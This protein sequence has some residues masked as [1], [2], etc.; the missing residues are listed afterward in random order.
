MTQAPP[1]Q[2]FIP[3]VLVVLIK[4]SLKMDR[5]DIEFYERLEAKIGRR[6]NNLEL[7][8]LAQ[9]NSEHSRHIFFRSSSL[10]KAVKSTL[11]DAT[12]GNSLVAFA[13]N[14]SAIRDIR[15]R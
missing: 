5:F 10:F 14:S 4:M 3:E 11:N 6:L 15:S 1:E 2:V 8:D 7:I 12:N 13:D 9:S